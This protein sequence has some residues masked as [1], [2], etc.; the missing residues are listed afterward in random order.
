MSTTQEPTEHLFLV[1]LSKH[2]VKP[3]LYILSIPN[4][5]PCREQEMWIYALHSP[6][7]QSS[8][9]EKYPEVNETWSSNVVID[10][11]KHNN[12][13]SSKTGQCDKEKLVKDSNNQEC[14]LFQNY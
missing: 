14:I 13:K 5:W 1:D 2:L 9:D 10:F 8:I 6:N 4:G 11:V 3:G 12:R 7:Y